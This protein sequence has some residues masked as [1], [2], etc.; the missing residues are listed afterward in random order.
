MSHNLPISITVSY[1]YITSYKLLEGLSDQFSVI[2]TDSQL[3]Y[4]K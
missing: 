1:S 3:E 4:T 2:Y